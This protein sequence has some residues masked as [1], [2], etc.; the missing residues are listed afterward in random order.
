M[1]G[2]SAGNDAAKVIEGRINVDRYSV[3]CDCFAYADA[4]CCDFV[5][6]VALARDPDSHATLAAFASHVEMAERPDEPFFEI[7]HKAPDVVLA[8]LEVK[9]DVA[10]TLAWAVISELSSAAGG[11]YRKAGG[12][13]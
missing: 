10:H 1:R 8:A 5:F 6:T 13:Q 9:H 4:E 7:K 3:K 2:D 11:K 12:G